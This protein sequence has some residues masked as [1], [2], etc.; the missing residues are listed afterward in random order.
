L[1]WR[2]CL[3]QLDKVNLVCTYLSRLCHPSKAHDV[4]DD[5]DV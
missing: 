5:D 1:F 2:R 3:F 4:D